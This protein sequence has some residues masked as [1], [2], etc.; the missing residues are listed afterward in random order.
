[1]AK[2]PKILI[3]TD[4]PAL[5]SGM[6]VGH[7]EVA[8]R[9]YATGRYE[10]ASFGWFFQNAQRQGVKWNFPWKQF[11]NPDTGNPYGHPKNWP[12]SNMEDIKNSPVFQVIDDMFKP[13]IVIA[14]ADYWMVDYLY[15]FT[16]INMHRFKLVHEVPIDGEP[17]PRHWTKDFKKA[18]AIISMSNYGKRVINDT[19]KNCNVTIIPRGID[20]GKFAKINAPKDMI[21]KTYMPSAVGEFI[22]GVF[23]RF[24]DR[25]QIGRAIESFAKFI[26]D[27]NHKKCSLYLH[28][29]INDPFSVSQKKMLD[30][31]Y[32]IIERFGIKDRIIVNKNITVEKG[33]PIQEL[34]A[35]YN[36]CDCRISTSQ[37][38]GWGYC[39]TESMACGIPNIGTAYTTFPEL[40]GENEERGLLSNV[41]TYLTGMY[42]I[43][44]ALVDTSHVAYQ[45]D[46]LYR[47]SV[48]RN[49]LGENAR[50]F[51][52]KFR[53]DVVIKQWEEVIDSLVT[54]TKYRLLDSKP[55]IPSSLKNCN[56]CDKEINVY[57]AVKENTGW[58][59]TTRG[60][61]N[62]L[63]Q[64]GWNVKISESG[65][66]SE[67]FKVDKNT[68][69][70]MQNGES[71][72]IAFINHMPKHAIQIA[73]ESNA[74][75]K[76]IYFPFE[77]DYM[78]SDIVGNINR[79]SDVY[80]CPTIFVENIAKKCGMVN[81][82]VIPLASDIN[83][84]ADEVE[85]TKK[86]YKFLMIGNLGDERKNCAFAIK[87]YLSAFT[88]DDDVCLVLKSMPGH[89]N[90]DPSE[91]IRIEKLGH[92]N[93]PE[94]KV[95]HCDD[96]D[97]AK[98]YASCDCL[99]MPSKCE[100]WGH[101]V[102]EALMFG[103]PVIASNYGGYLDFINKGKNIQLVNGAM[104][105][106]IASPEYK[107]SEQWFEPDFNEFI[108]AMKKSYALKMRK[109]NEN[110]VS[111]YSWENTAKTIENVCINKIDKNKKIKVY[112]ERLIKNLWN[113]DNE[114]G[115]K[116][117]APTKY[118]FVQEPD[119]ADFQ[120]IDITRISDK[121]YIK[122]KDYV[123]LFHT[124]GEWAD[125]PP[126]LYRELFENA[127]LVYS[128]MDLKPIFPDINFIR[129]A[130]GCHTDVWFGLADRNNS[131]YQIL[132][133]G[134]IAKTEGIEEC[135]FACDNLGVKML[136][137]GPNF[138]YKNFSYT[139]T[140][141]LTGEQMRTA[142][143]DC[144]WVSGLRRIEG[145]EK[146]VCEGLLCG[147][148]PVCFDTPLYRYWYGDLARYVKEGTD[149]ETYNDIVKVMKEEY[150]PVTDTEKEFAIEKFGWK[151]VAKRFWLKIN[152]IMEGA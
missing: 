39:T 65:G 11:T 136:H 8:S 67:G 84:E 147:C 1:M 95:V 61:A 114:I 139:T 127:M 28:M 56:T 55:F 72:N 142:Y 131:K 49:R 66:V 119:N 33:V 92:I 25:K 149:I 96:S 52:Y 118:E 82:A 24:Q 71:N 43:E 6:G 89:P 138:Q 16:D 38:E 117:Y 78:T 60:I 35:L 141:N 123:V 111:E 4:S 18:D 87:S 48:L 14:M 113:K 74:R 97:I 54:R 79:L 125:E 112:Y 36:C 135:V 144:K 130:W 73:S 98:Y 42:N 128:H 7:R 126:E 102:F 105:N 80:A 40:L 53:W 26:S 22:V 124:F 2:K 20:I 27:G 12:N 46:R 47:S 57:G 81:T 75:Y 34:N 83:T 50:K 68:H 85:L 104:V 116:S 30:G 120:I 64:L 103:M 32:G 41:Q 148:R 88:G 51:V 151:N 19:D 129:G 23:D 62:G 121:N 110:Y 44:R 99:L 9:L 133:T 109:T 115:F 15:K 150:E 143:N 152:N 3:I 107:N 59:I 137:V 90:S 29:N 21:R 45:L 108:G 76:I 93:P 134:E 106:A 17:I 146:P 101:P 63:N 86:S 91:R 58:A 140:S 100:G 69:D 77:L 13:D 94:I 37:G 31:D 132:C 5:D 10:I 145:F 70:M 122:C